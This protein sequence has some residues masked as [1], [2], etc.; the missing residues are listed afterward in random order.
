MNF[1]STN[2]S[3][4]PDD[5]IPVNIISP[6]TP[7]TLTY[8]QNNEHY[9]QTFSTWNEHEQVCFVENLLKHMQSHQHGQVNLYLLPMLKR[10]FIGRL[11]FHGLAH[12]SEKILGYLDDQSLSSTE[13]VCREWY[14]VIS[15]GMLW[16]KL[17]ERKFLSDSLWRGLVDRRGL[18]KYLFRQLKINDEKP[19]RHDFYRQLYPQILCDIKQLESNWRTGTFQLEKIQCR[20]QSSKG[21]YCLQYDDEKIISGLRDN[22]IKIWDRKSLECI[23]VL[24]GHN[25]SVLCL[26]YDEKVIVTG[27]SDSTVRVWN[28]KT[29]ELLNTLL[30]HCEAVLHLRFINGTMVTCSKDRSIAVWQ[31]NS[32]ADITIRRVLVGHR[33]AVNVVDF[34]DKYIVSASGDRTIKVWDTTTCEFVRTLLGHKRGI[35]C[36]QYRDKI[37]VSGSSDNTIRVWDIECGVCLRI[38]EGHDELVRCI[39]F[40]SKRIVSG[41]YD[42]KIKIW[43]LQAA[44]DPRSQTSSL[45]IKTLTEH[46]GRVFRLQFDEFQIISSSHDDTILC[47]NFLQPESTSLALQKH[48][49]PSALG[50][51]QIQTTNFLPSPLKTMNSSD[52][53]NTNESASNVFQSQASVH[54]TTSS[55]SSS[56]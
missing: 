39:R 2:N 31:M 54:S 46:T 45:C 35:A 48:S 28:V 3:S 7:S 36:L 32:P 43:D 9:M 27:S 41:A 29:G 51:C 33:A 25:G 14:H 19:K 49:S 22:T 52:N 38:L 10:D 5:I 17:I 56:G 47:F 24:T 21:V 15:E 16:K 30:H 42:G 11:A 34:D 53:D 40:D 1:L 20:S 55:S 37:V 23:Q 18:S 26:Q 12:V 4:S 8:E 6:K 50:R 44:L 13:L